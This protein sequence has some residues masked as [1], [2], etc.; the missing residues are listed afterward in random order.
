MTVNNELTHINARGEARMVDVGAKEET[1][2]A[3]VA[4][5]RVLMSRK[6][7]ELIMENRMPK[8]DVLAVARVAGIMAAKK[9]G[10]LI[11][12]CHPLTVSAVNI[13]FRPNY[14]LG[15]LEIQARVRTV[16][17]TGVE[18]EALMA[19]GMA[20]LTVYDM[21]KAAERGIVVDNIRLVEKT[22]GRSGYYLREGEEPWGE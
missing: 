18:M 19:A 21:C 3:A 1:E 22:G 11:P 16:A 17:R 6:T 7:L 5:A 8:G 9:T 10:S 2:R 13:D 4:G 15:A 12:L 20:A 14:E